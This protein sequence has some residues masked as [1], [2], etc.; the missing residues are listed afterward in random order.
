MSCYISSSTICKLSITSWIFHYVFICLFLTWEFD[1][2]QIGIFLLLKPK[3]QLIKT[4]YLHHQVFTEIHCRWYNV[5]IYNVCIRIGMWELRSSIYE[6]LGTFVILFNWPCWIS[7]IFHFISTPPPVWTI[8]SITPL[9][10]VKICFTDFANFVPTPFGKVL[11]PH[12][13]IH[14]LGRPSWKMPTKPVWKMFC[15]ES[16]WKCLYRQ[17]PTLPEGLQTKHCPT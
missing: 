10:F 14:S 2:Q 6:P 5:I 7:W 1:I 17:G 9:E 11:S 13:N 12:W 16:L 4:F 3:A 8:I 15:L